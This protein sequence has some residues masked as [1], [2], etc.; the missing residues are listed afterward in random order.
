MTGVQTC[1][2]PILV[3]KFMTH[4][5]KSLRFYKRYNSNNSKTKL[6]KDN[7][8]KYSHIRGVLVFQMKIILMSLE[9]K[10]KIFKSNEFGK[11]IRTS[12]F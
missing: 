1:A 2:L 4:Y 10:S 12:N 6:D 8:L 7:E 3:S 11:N 9:S 5:Y